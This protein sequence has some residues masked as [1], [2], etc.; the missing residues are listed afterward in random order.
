[1]NKGWR[2]MITTA[3]EARVLTRKH[4]LDVNAVS[5][6]ISQCVQDI[7]WAANHVQYDTVFLGTLNRDDI[8]LLKE[9]G[10]K[11]S[12]YTITYH[13]ICCAETYYKISWEE[14][15]SLWKLIKGW[16]C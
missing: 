5:I 4:K 13:N 10:F 11:V 2:D 14:H 7:H 3:E 6:S 9:K 15:V 12:K 16:F 8:K 1:M